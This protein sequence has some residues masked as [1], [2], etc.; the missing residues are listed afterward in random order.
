MLPIS[1]ESESILSEKNE[2]E[3]SSER[4]VFFSWGLSDRPQTPSAEKVLIFFVG[5][6]SCVQTFAVI[7]LA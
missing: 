3:R 4:M 5:F 6:Y 7:I 1:G 2:S